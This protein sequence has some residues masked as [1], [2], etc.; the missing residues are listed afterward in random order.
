MTHLDG[1]WGFLRLLCSLWPSSLP[2]GHGSCRVFQDG[3]RSVRNVLAICTCVFVGILSH[4]AESVKCHHGGPS[5]VTYACGYLLSLCD[6]VSSF[7]PTEQELSDYPGLLVHTLMGVTG[8][9]GL[10][11][12]WGGGT[13]R[14]QSCWPACRMSLFQEDSYWLWQ[15]RTILGKCTHQCHETQGN[16]STQT[17]LTKMVFFG[18]KKRDRQQ[19]N[20]EAK[21][22]T[23][24]KALM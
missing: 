10:G 16:S 23:D 14:G 8:R 2:V 7:W 11:E 17:L 15:V 6:S 21:K 24:K 18:C 12:G 13:K 22:R 4:W 3:S 19:K 9:E 20:M 1:L 5:Y